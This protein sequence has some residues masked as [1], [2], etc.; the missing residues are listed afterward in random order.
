LMLAS[1][2]IFGVVSYSVRQRT[3]EI[4]V[5]IAL[6]AG[7]GDIARMILRQGLLMTGAGIATGAG[8]AVWITGYLRS[9]LYAVNPL[10]VSVYVTVA[11][12]LALVAMVACLIP[13][14]RAMAIDPIS[15]LRSE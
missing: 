1:I 11:A 15:A 12:L 14:R 5:R 4:G 8:A 2:G 6:G 10:D 9:Q 3:A 13:A 7:G